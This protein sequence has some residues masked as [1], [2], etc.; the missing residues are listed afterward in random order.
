MRARCFALVFAC[1]ALLG[2]ALAQASPDIQQWTTPTGAAVY[3]VAAPEIPILDLRLVFAAGSARDGGRSGV[4]ALTN[5]LLD[6]GSAKHT[7][8]D[9]HSQLDAT[10]ALL[11]TGVMRDMAWI[12]LRSLTAEPQRTTALDLL[13]ELLRGPRL[14]EE[15]FTRQRARALA[16]LK[17][18]EESPGTIGGRAFFRALYGDHPY[19]TPTN[20]TPASV[21]GLALD[22]VV[23][24]FRQHY[25]AHNMTIALVGALSRAEAE[26]LATRLAAELAAGEPAP[27]LPPLPPYAPKT[28]HLEFASA[29]SHV[30]VGQRGIAREDPD[31]FPLVV[32][33]HV[34]GGNGVVSLLF[35]EIREKRGL[36]YSVESHFEPMALPGPYMATLQTSNEQLA[37]AVTLL[38]EQIAQYVAK[39]PSDADFE[40]AKRNLVGGF[41]LRID[42]NSKIV[43]NLAVIG[44]YR[45]PLDWLDTY[46]QKVQAVSKAQ[47]MEAVQ[48]RLEPARMVQIT[49][50]RGAVTPATP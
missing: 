34:L 50:G 7:A 14:D 37:A 3:F 31:Y 49:V 47:A 28:E 27:P 18:A 8:D 4:A 23:R 41:P 10:G 48:R 22:D 15:S 25:V 6:E 13:A 20:G 35:E 45:L 11:G 29:Q 46:T 36:S 16:A 26:A 40:A 38:R 42:N 19:G 33:N 2:G 43:E 39:G 17:Q 21:A 32:A 12:S 5:A 9:F 24:F 30:Y 44:F 1:G